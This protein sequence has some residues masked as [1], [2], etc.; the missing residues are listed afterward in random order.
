MTDREIPKESGSGITIGGRKTLEE[1]V[2]EEERKEAGEQA[3]PDKVYP[4]HGARMQY[5][6]RKDRNGKPRT[7]TQL[8]LNQET[9]RQ[10]MINFDDKTPMST[11]VL[12]ALIDG[13]WQRIQ[14]LAEKIR[15]NVKNRKLPQHLPNTISS[16]MTALRYGELRWFFEKREIKGHVGQEWRLAPC[17]IAHCT[18]DDLVKLGRKSNK[19]YTA[20]YLAE[21]SGPIA[22]YLGNHE[23]YQE[24]LASFVGPLTATETKQELEQAAEQLDRVLE[25]GSLEEPEDEV[26][27][28]SEEYVPGQRMADLIEEGQQRVA[29]FMKDMKKL[30]VDVNVNVTVRFVFGEKK[31]A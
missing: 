17:L 6:Q 1:Y 5:Q 18:L 4:F 23:Q 19:E 26:L 20:A 31:D 9:W 22:K 3:Q 12:G 11:V 21:E 27:A 25:T 28:K 16:T 14:T 24:Y 7:W 2:A 29:G 13:E 10:A 15:T 8:E 30:G